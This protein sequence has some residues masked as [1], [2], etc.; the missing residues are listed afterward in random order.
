MDVKRRGGREKRMGEKKR[1]EIREDG[2]EY[3]RKRNGEQCN[4]EREG[5]GREEEDKRRCGDGSAEN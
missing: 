4:G 2:V 5:N 3:N 1:K